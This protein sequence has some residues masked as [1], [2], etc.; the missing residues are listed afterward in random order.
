MPNDNVEEMKMSFKTSP[1]CIHHSNNWFSQESVKDATINRSKFDEEQDIYID[2]KKNSNFTVR[3]PKYT[4]KN[5]WLNL[6]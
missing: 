5:K 4:N 6:R 3:N 2:T 1:L